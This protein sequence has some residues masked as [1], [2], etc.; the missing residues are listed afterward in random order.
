[1]HPLDRTLSKKVPFF[2]VVPTLLILLHQ[3]TIYSR[4]HGSVKQDIIFNGT[5]ANLKK[6]PMASG[7]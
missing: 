7:S 1:M 5:I 2:F 3:R 4:R 6:S